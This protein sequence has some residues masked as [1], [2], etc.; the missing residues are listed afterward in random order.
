MEHI[1]DAL[2]K[3][4]VLYRSS[5]L[6]TADS[7]PAHIVS[8]ADI[9]LLL[10]AV[11]AENED[12]AVFKEASHDTSHGYI[13]GISRNSGDKAANA[14]YYQVYLNTGLRSLCHFIHDDLVAEGVYLCGDIA[15]S[16]VFSNSYLLIHHSKHLRSECKRRYQQLSCLFNK[17]AV[18]K[19]IENIFCISSDIPV[20]GEEHQV[21]IKSGGLFVV[22][23][24]ADLSNVVESAALSL[25]CNEKEL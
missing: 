12:T 16:A 10:L 1:T 25:S 11:C 6:H 14:S 18:E 17:S 3:L 13:I 23:A 7:V 15:F 9:Y 21:C 20:S 5:D 19:C 24:G 2:F 8:G 4:F 22:V